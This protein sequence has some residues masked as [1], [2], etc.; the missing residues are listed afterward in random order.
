M[1]KFFANKISWAF[2]I[3]FNDCHAI[4]SYMYNSLILR[5]SGTHTQNITDDGISC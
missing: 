2:F 4:S 5:Q 1:A 3:I